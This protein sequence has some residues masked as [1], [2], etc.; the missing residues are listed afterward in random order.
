LAQRSQLGDG[1]GAGPG[2]DQIGSGV[3]QVDLLSVTKASQAISGRI[4]L[5]ELVDTLLRIV[6]ENAGAQTGHLLLTRG[7]ALLPAAEAHV[8][9]HAV[10]VQVQL[11]AEKTLQATDLPESILNYVRRSQTPVL[12]SDA[13]QANPF[14][15]D[16]RLARRR[17]KSVLCL[18]ITRQ[19]TL[20]GLLYLENNL[21]AH[22]FTPERLTVLELLAAQAAISLENA[23]LYADLQRE[24]VERQRAEASL[25]ERDRS[26]RRLVESN[27][28]GVFFWNTAGEITEANDAFLRLVGY[29]RQELLSGTVRWPD[30]TPQEYREADAR[31]IAELL[32]AGAG[33]P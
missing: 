17:S 30:M 24:N 31:A 9:Q 33:T 5:D 20:I 10:Q 12:L 29:T 16:P 28:I 25:S 18:P 7:A 13:S 26:V 6:L 21:V 19:S 15:Y 22:A 32:E 23:L 3:G 8:E 27:I 4:V 1:R 2:E 11:H 14:S